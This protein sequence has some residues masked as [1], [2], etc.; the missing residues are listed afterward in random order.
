MPRPLTWTPGTHAAG[1][2]STSSDTDLI[3]ACSDQAGDDRELGHGVPGHVR[4][5]PQVSGWDDL[6]LASFLATGAVA[7]IGYAQVLYVLPVSLFGMS[8]AAAE[9]PELARRRGE[10]SG[11]LRERTR[12]ALS[13]VAFYVVPSFL[14]FVA[15]GDVIVAALYQTGQFGRSDTLLVY[16]TLCG[17]AIGLLASTSSRLLSYTF[18]ALRDTR[19]PARCAAAQVSVSAVLGAVLMVQFERIDPFG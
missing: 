8:V 9:L 16:L 2:A 17:Y 13:R 4:Q 14:A 5:E 3:N 6:V 12:A 19:T 18:F 11:V 15:L 1:A 7:A 10:A